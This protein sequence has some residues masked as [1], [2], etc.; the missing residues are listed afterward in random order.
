MSKKLSA[1]LCRLCLARALRS[2]SVG[3]RTRNACPRQG[4]GGQETR[5]AS[6]VSADHTSSAM[7]SAASASALGAPSGLTT[8]EAIAWVRDYLRALR[9]GRLKPF[10]FT[11]RKARAATRAEP[12]GPTGA[13]LKELAALSF[14]YEHATLIFSAMRHRMTAPPHLWRKVYKA[15]TVIEFL[16]TRGS[17][18]CAPPSSRET[19]PAPQRGGCRA[20]LLPLCSR[21]PGLR[22]EERLAIIHAVLRR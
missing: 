3:G 22:A 2:C 8:E 12:W 15:L 19:A 20:A 18:E 1:A 17:E 6:R 9:H 4:G 13:Q 10:T 5:L 7:R 21:C 16:V 14:D 11:E